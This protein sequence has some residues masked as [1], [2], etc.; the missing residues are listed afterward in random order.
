VR[1]RVRSERGD[2]TVEAVL[3]TPV[4]L[5]LI[6][7]V[8]QFGL[9]YH[10]VHTAQAAAQEGVRAARVEGAT[11]VDGQ[12]RAE[13]FMADAA[14]TLVDDVAVDASRDTEAAHVT[15]RGT[16]HSLI[17]GVELPVHAE[18]DSPIERFRA[19]TP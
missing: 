1:A 4:L 19:D 5:L 15:V 8:I 18:A 6:L 17:P 2:A 13:G 16:L 7:T 12:R 9:W 11:A 3:A 10:A 14:P